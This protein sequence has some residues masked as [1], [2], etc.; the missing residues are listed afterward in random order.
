MYGRA[1]DC[2]NSST[3]PAQEQFIFRQ[4]LS[5]DRV[6]HNFTDEILYVLNDKIPIRLQCAHAEASD[7][8]NYDILVPP[9]YFYG[10]KSK[11]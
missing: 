5:V 1:T 2:L 8:E 7:C 6:L 3:I 10:L 4:G 11:F 9:L